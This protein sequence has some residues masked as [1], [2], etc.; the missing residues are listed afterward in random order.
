MTSHHNSSSGP[1]LQHSASGGSARSR[2]LV[3]SPSHADGEP[4]LTILYDGTMLLKFGRKGQAHERL[5]RLT[6]DNRYIVW[7]SNIFAFKR[8]E[9]SRGT[10]ITS[11]EV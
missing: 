4:D 9:D 1:Q 11:T 7:K 6:Q 3:S 10:A 2:K 5:F 8:A